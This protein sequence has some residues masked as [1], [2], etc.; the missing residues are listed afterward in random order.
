MDGATCA[1]GV[2]VGS[3]K[4]KEVVCA[5]RLLGSTVTIKLPGKDR[6][7]ALCEVAV[8]A[9]P[10]GEAPRPAAGEAEAEAGDG[11][12]LGLRLGV[13]EFSGDG[14]DDDGYDDQA[15]EEAA[16]DAAAAAVAAAAGATVEVGA[17]GVGKG[18]S[19]GKGASSGVPGGDPTLHAKMPPASKKSGNVFRVGIFLDSVTLSTR[20][21]HPNGAYVRRAKRDRIDRRSQIMLPLLFKMSPRSKAAVERQERGAR[22]AAEARKKDPYYVLGVAKN[23]TQ[24]AVRKAYRAL[25]RKYHPDRNRNNNNNNK[26]RGSSNGDGDGGGEAD[27]SSEA[28]ADRFAAINAAYS[29]IGDP[30]KRAFFDDF[31]GANNAGHLQTWQYASWAVQFRRNGGQV[32]HARPSARTPHGAHV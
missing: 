18:A 1:E 24:S 16:D 7:L 12:G 27:G 8:N 20:T 30:D 32:D 31:G 15:E 22:E 9:V 26:R 17:E 4:T 6:L 21:M 28:M 3:G 29:V 5:R 13:D 23:A 2:A 11:L 10:A 25:G 19:N 14:Y